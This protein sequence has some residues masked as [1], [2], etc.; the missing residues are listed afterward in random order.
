MA[1][2]AIT[3]NSVGATTLT[4]TVLSA[5]DTLAYVPGANQQLYLANNTGG[6]LTVTLTG[7]TAPAT[8]IIPG[9]GGATIAPS[10]GKTIGPIAASSTVEVSL[11]DLSLY[12]QGVITITGGTGIVAT[13]LSN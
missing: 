3:P 8:Y 4:R 6:A 9:T 13:V 11:D 12:L 10:A 7:S 1:A 2:I 5:S